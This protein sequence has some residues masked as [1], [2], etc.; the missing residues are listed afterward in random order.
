METLLVANHIACTLLKTIPILNIP[1]RQPEGLSSMGF[2]FHSHGQSTLNNMKKKVDKGMQVNSATKRMRHSKIMCS[3][4]NH[5]NHKEINLSHGLRP[6]Y[7]LETEL[8]VSW[9][10]LLF[11]YCLSWSSHLIYF[12]NCDSEANWVKKTKLKA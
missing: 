8:Q 6:Y 9:H 11:Q 2:W 12:I 7:P 3:N 4:V 5:I 10:H 1:P